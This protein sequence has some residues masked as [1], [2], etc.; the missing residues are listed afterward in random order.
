[1][2]TIY[3]FSVKDA[4]LKSI[5]LE[6][7]RD[8]IL[9]IV[10]VASNC[11]LTY[12]YAGIEGLYKKYKAI[13]FEVLAFPCNQF[14]FQEPGTNEEIKKFCDIKYG[15]TFK[16]FNKIN[17]NGSKSDPVYEF[18]KNQLP[19]VAGTTQIKWNFTKF[20]INKNGEVIER[21]SPQAEADEIEA[22]IKKLL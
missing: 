14:A 22:S 10:N 20:L 3:D 18:L 7:Y 12:Q 2:K 19:G 13:G 5:S 4:D 21:F 15:V 6:S 8:K 16:I 17:V 1:M 11:G 9:L